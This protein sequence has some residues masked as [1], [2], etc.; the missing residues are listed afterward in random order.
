MTLFRELRER[1]LWNFAEAFVLLPR[2]GEKGVSSESVG[3]SESVG[4][5]FPDDGI[6]LPLHR[7][8]PSSCPVLMSEPFGLQ[9]EMVMS[10]EQSSDVVVWLVV[11]QP[12]QTKQSVN[13]TIPHDYHTECCALNVLTL[14]H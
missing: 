10:I 11:T 2:V 13:Q 8:L 9:L 1:F 5:K 7:V 6:C 3:G 4:E 12:A 14:S